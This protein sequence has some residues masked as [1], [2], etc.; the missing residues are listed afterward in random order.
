MQQTINDSQKFVDMLHNV[1]WEDGLTNDIVMGL[2]YCATLA[3]LFAGDGEASSSNVPD[4]QPQHYLS[5]TPVTSQLLSQTASDL[6]AL[7]RQVSLTKP[8]PSMVVNTK[9]SALQLKSPSVL[10]LGLKLVAE[11]AKDQM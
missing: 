5:T 9:C 1:P 2:Y 6:Q 4:P 11:L 3:I 8:D 7:F 10:A